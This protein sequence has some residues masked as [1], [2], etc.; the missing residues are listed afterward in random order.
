MNVKDMEMYKLYS[1]QETREDGIMRAFELT[2]NQI[3]TI[4]LAYYPGLREREVYEDVLQ[5]CRLEILRILP[6]YDL[7][8]NIRFTTFCDLYIKNR[9]MEYINK[10]VNGISSYENRTYGH[11]T[12]SNF[13]ESYAGKSEESTEKIVED[14]YNKQVVEQFLSCLNPKH[15]YLLRSYYGIDC[16][17]KTVKELARELEMTTTQVNRMKQDCLN[18]IRRKNSF[19]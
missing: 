7:S 4:F 14:I 1:N 12:F 18:K 2:E 16:N 10:S 11:P 17:P 3:R 5:E 6:R 8:R 13:E 9:M 19:Y 15:Q